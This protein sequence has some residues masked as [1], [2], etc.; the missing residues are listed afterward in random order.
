MKYN[1]NI[2]LSGKKNP[3]TDLWTLPLGSNQGKTSHHVNNVILPAAPV[4][5][6][7]HANMKTQIAF[8]M[9]TVCNKANK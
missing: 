5:A 9:H 3:S 6:N 8:F 4:Y 2:I 7:A 1:S